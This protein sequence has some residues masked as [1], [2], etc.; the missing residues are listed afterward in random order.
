VAKTAG[1]LFDPR[2][3]DLHAGPIISDTSVAI[4]ELVANAWDAYATDVAITWPNQRDNSRFSIVDNGRGMTPAQFDKRWRQIDYNRVV[5]EGTHVD[6][7]SDLKGHAQRKVYGRNGRGRYAGFRFS[8]PYTVRTWRDGT[9]ITYEVK[10]GIIQPFEVKEV[11]RRSGVQ[12][13]G[14]EIAAT[15][16]GGVLMPANEAREIIGLR[17]LADPSF[18]VSVDGIRV[19]FE[20]VPSMFL[21]EI[22]VPVASF[23]T[24]HLI[25][26]DTAKADKT[27]QRH[28]IAWR[29]KTRLVGNQGWVGFDDE[30]I[31]DG[32]TTE[33][34]RFQ[35]IVFADF[36]DG[37]IL[38]DW[39]AFN[40]SSE[41]WQATRSAV[42]TAV[43]AFLSTFTAERR[44]EA[45]A[46]V[47]QTLVREVCQLSPAGRSM[48]RPWTR[49]RTC[50]RC[51][52]VLSGFSVRSSRVSSSLQ[53]GG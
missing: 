41:A 30:R 5:D 27:T 6:P 53:T 50:S 11:N 47:K 13:H 33:A 14:T 49:L 40:P 51:S 45:K 43:T 34:K 12:G 28:G 8:D 39:S 23:G 26:I 22:E 4:V 25:V 2:F 18:R 24:A 48:T 37:H 46:A 52:S 15:A 44:N 35:I 42:H 16:L 20:D 31:L 19:T 3:L 7:P 36:L 38:P 29:V 21:Q 10:R 32:R 9:E 1:V 17:F